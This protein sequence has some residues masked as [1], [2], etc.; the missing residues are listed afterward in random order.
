VGYGEGLKEMLEEIIINNLWA[1]GKRIY[2]HAS[3]AYL[4]EIN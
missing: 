3:F 1:F 2:N 4:E